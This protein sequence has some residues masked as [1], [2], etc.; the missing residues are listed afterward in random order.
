[1]ADGKKPNIVDTAKDLLAAG[2]MVNK[3]VTEGITKGRPGGPTLTFSLP[4]WEDP[5]LQLKVPARDAF[6]PTV[7]FTFEVD[8]SW[9]QPIK[10]FGQTIFD[11]ML[12]K[13]KGS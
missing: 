11:E 10:D 1:M 6:K 12:K 3:L 5:R 9:H 13:I 2:Q 8:L 7:T 4:N